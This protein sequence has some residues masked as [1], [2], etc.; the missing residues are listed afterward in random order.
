VWRDLARRELLGAQAYP[1]VKSR[2]WIPGVRL[3]AA[4]EALEESFGT[5]V[6]RL[7]TIGIACGYHHERMVKA[8]QG[9]ETSTRQGWHTGGGRPR[10]ARSDRRRDHPNPHRAARRQANRT[11]ELDP[12]RAP[13]LY[14]STTATSLAGSA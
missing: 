13:S 5:I 2:A 3:C 8:R 12:L 7:G 9:L 11:L 14:T 10:G 4:D 6:L 1:K